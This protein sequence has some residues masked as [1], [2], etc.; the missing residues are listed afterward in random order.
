MSLSNVKISKGVSVFEE[1]NS[2]D[3]L[4][5]AESL[6]LS[7]LIDGT[8]L[9]DDILQLT[10][11]RGG[12]MSGNWSAIIER[13]KQLFKEQTIEI[14]DTQ[15]SWLPVSIYHC[16]CPEVEGATVKIE[17]KDVASSEGETSVEVLGVGGGASF[18]LEFSSSL[19]VESENKSFA[20]VYEFESKWE[21]VRL[22]EPDGKS[23]EFCRLAEVNSENR[24]VSTVFLNTPIIDKTEI[25]QQEQIS[26]KKETTGT[27]KIT[28]KSGSELKVSNKLKLEQFGIEIGTEITTANQFEIS[29]TYSLPG[30]RVYKLIH[31]KNT[32]YCLW[33]VKY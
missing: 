12:Y 19:K 16:Y 32:A 3:L 9:K 25:D 1:S 7:G 30:G 33:E 5:K 11:N 13:L 29:Y 8:S 23:V 10:S 24:K 2:K 26:L 14:L 28:I 17:Y 15:T 6:A 31:P 27:K 20:L 4:Q 22:T 18:T 21:Q